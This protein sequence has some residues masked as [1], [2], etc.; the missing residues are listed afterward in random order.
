MRDDGGHAGV[1][2]MQRQTQQRH[3]RRARKLATPEPTVTVGEEEAS[4]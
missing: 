1:L 3:P 2:R 4:R